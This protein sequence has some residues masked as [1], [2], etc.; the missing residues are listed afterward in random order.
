MY[1]RFLL[2][3]LIYPMLLFIL[4]MMRASSAAAVVIILSRVPRLQGLV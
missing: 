3:F 4:Y 2:A 1:D